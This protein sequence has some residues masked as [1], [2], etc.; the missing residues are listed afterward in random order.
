MQRI[1]ELER[2]DSSLSA[3]GTASSFHQLPRPCHYFDYV[4][5][6]STG[7]YVHHAYPLRVVALKEMI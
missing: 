5:G 3:I 4:F 1:A 6:S 2:A 7:G